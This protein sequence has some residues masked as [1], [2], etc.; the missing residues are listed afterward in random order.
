MRHCAI[1]NKVIKKADICNSCFKLWC[2]TGY[3][4]WV[5]ELIRIQKSFDRMAASREACYGNTGDLETIESTL[6]G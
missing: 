3:P 4:D 2:S 6:K 1:C 5:T